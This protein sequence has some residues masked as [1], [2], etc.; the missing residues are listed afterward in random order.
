MVAQHYRWDF[1]GLSTDEKP[2]PATSEKVVDGSTFYCSDNS[3]LY[4]WCDSQWYEKTATGGGGGTTYTAGDG[5]TIVDD[6][7]SVDLVQETGESTTKV[8]SQK[9]ISDALSSVGGSTIKTLTVADA[10]FP[11]GNPTAIALWKLEAGIYKKGDNTNIWFCNG[12]SQNDANNSV[13]SGWSNYQ[14]MFIVGLPVLWNGEPASGKTLMAFAGATAG[15]GSTAPYPCVEW[16]VYNNGNNQGTASN[17][18][19]YVK[20]NELQA[21]SGAS[22]PTSSTAPRYLGDLYIDTTNQDCYVNVQVASGNN[23]WKKITP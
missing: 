8:M 21:K 12:A 16:A 18:I 2:T 9:A 4:V 17:T 22:A 3:K 15:D 5:I 19:R 10:N 13:I 20:E 7:I 6:T 23:I 14:T 11:E 1:I